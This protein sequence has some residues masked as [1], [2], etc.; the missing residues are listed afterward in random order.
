ML[1]TTEKPDLNN[2]RAVRVC[3]EVT[4]L[5]SRTGEEPCFYGIFKKTGHGMGFS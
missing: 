3:P 2:A 5:S 4:A 1:K